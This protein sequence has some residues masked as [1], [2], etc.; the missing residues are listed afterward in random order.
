MTHHPQLNYEP[1]DFA[2]TRRFIDSLPENERQNEALYAISCL[3][4]QFV[5]CVDGTAPVVSD[6]V[7]DVIQFAYDLAYAF[8]DR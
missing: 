5:L 7:G 3:L 6:E 2:D 8:N 1:W 4:W